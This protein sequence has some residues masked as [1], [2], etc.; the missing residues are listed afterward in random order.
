VKAEKVA[1]KS[2]PVNAFARRPRGPSRT[3]GGNSASGNR[4]MI[5]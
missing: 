2:I 1:D 3:P 4:Y 5:A